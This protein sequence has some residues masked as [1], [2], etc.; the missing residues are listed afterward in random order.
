MSRRSRIMPQASAPQHHWSS[1]NM[2]IIRDLA[3]TDLMPRQLLL[4][5]EERIRLVELGE[6]AEELPFVALSYCLGPPTPWTIKTTKAN[7][8]NMTTD[9]LALSELPATFA[10]HH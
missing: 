9:D 2:Y 1:D 3:F 7:L 4:I 8:G 5:D 10:R 6:Q